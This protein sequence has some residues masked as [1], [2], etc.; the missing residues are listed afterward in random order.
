MRTLCVFENLQLKP[1]VRYSVSRYPSFRAP[2][3]QGPT[4]LP[5]SPCSWPFV[6]SHHSP[7]GSFL[8]TSLW[9]GLHHW[10]NSIPF[11]FLLHTYLWG[12]ILRPLAP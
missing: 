1:F 6:E 3:R 9:A 10:N 11:C 4:R 5:C 12:C 7:A 8:A 2:N